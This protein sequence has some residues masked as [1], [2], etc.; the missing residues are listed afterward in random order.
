MGGLGHTG[1]VVVAGVSLIFSQKRLA[2]GACTCYTARSV[3][4]PLSHRLVYLPLG[5]AFLL[6]SCL[7]QQV[8][9]THAPAVK[10]LQKKGVIE[11]AA[12]VNERRLPSGATL[13]ID[14]AEKGDAAL[15][16]L[17]LQAGANPNGRG[18]S[19][20]AVPLTRTQ[21]AEVV[22]SLLAADAEVNITDATGTTPLSRALSTG[23]QAGADA[24]LRAGASTAPALPADPPLLVVRD[25][26]AALRLLEAGA[27]VNQA[28]ARGVTPL[29][30]AVARNDEELV[31]FFIAKGAD[32]RAVD[33]SGNTALH[34][35]R[36]AEIVQALCKAGANPAA[37]NARGETALFDI[38]HTPSTVRALIAAGV[39]LDVISTADGMSALLSKLSNER[40]D[41][42]SILLLIRAGADVQLR[43]PGG[44]T[45]LSLAQKRKSKRR[46]AII[47][48]L[49][50]RGAGK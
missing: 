35:A 32:V 38:L 16:S 28:S 8:A 43:T 44:E 26:A 39:P 3:M 46:V 20:G 6:S 41:D 15:V 23:N 9:S 10:E 7:V 2:R 33:A 1:M 19:I 29:M 18:Y 5:A 50:Q 25:A 22:L 14:A 40:E 12:E 24:L 30:R 11:F 45:A 34:A 36:S 49:L 4:K 21:S 48:A 31:S 42:E 13:L 37:V 47:R 17:L 27:D